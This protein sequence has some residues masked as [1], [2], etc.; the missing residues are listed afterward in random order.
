MK[1][2]AAE[3]RRTTRPEALEQGSETG[4]G[5]KGRVMGGPVAKGNMTHGPLPIFSA[6]PG[7]A[8]V[9]EAISSGSQCGD[10]HKEK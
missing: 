5:G 8:N 3:Q 1:C 4:S 10:T 6:N 9:P 2:S 7:I